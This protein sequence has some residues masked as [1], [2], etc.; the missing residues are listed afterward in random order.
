MQSLINTKDYSATELI[1]FGVGCFCWI[2]VYFYTL[3]SIKEKQ[4][5]EIPLI[6]V[7]GNIIW[8]FLWSW[9][10]HTDMG[11]LFQWGYRIWFFMDCLIVYG[12]FRYGY[13]QISIPFFRDKA[14]ALIILA[15]LSWLP[16]LYFY[17]KNYDA[18]ISHMGAYSGYILNVMISALYIPL[19]IR[20]NDWKMFS[21]PAAWYKAIGNLLINIFCFLHFNDWFLLSLC[22][23]TSILDAYYLFLFYVYRR[24]IITSNAVV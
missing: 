16:L 5:I 4:F 21:Y 22:I 14:K 11:N 6:T 9:V 12:L 23:L 18:P 20:L 10:F 8:E 15:M 19:V 3:K 17:I 13:K 2:I 7:C 24:T 1:T